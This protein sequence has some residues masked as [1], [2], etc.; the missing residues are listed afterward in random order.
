MRVEP[1]IIGP[2]EDNAD[3]LAPL[4]ANPR[5]TSKGHQMKLALAGKV[6]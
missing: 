3:G 4:I 2:G 6:L 5:F 1:L